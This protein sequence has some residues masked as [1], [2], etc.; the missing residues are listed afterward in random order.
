M[1]AAP[2]HMNGCAGALHAHMQC[3]CDTVTEHNARICEHMLAHAR[4]P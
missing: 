3:W 1:R 2:R 4:F